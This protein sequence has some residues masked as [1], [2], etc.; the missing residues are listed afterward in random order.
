LNEE[1]VENLLWHQ[2]NRG[3]YQLSIVAR[4]KGPLVSN[5]QYIL[6]LEDPQG[7]IIDYLTTLNG[8]KELGKLFLILHEFCKRR[9]Y[10]GE[11]DVDK[12]KELLTA[13]NIKKFVDFM[14]LSRARKN[15]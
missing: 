15:E 12:L 1:I 13:E 3:N 4:I 5:V 2:E 11:K 10:P 9:I 6:R 8:F 7:Q 14:K